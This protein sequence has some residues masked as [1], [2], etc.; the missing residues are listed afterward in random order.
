MGV[1][2]PVISGVQVPTLEICGEAAELCDVSDPVSIADAVQSVLREPERSRELS[3]RGV[4]RAEA[5]SWTGVADRYL[6]L[7][8]RLEGT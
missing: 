2:C 4:A 6:E 5:F 8:V 3:R 7:M 1:G